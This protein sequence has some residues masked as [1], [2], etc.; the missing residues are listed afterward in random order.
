M[1]W[2]LQCST[3]Y[4]AFAQFNASVWTFVPQTTDPARTITPK[5]QLFTHAR[6]TYKFVLHLFAFHQYVPLVGNHISL[7]SYCSSALF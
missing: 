7:F 2:A 5:D 3:N 1:E 6:D 4:L